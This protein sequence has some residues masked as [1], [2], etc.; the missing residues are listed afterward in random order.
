MEQAIYDKNCIYI[1]DRTFMKNEP[2]K[3]YCRIWFKKMLRHYVLNNLTKFN[4]IA[5][6]ILHAQNTSKNG[7]SI[8]KK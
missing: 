3:N 5:Q 4:L 7:H 6:F 8:F 2:Y 1:K